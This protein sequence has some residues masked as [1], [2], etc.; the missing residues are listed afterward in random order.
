MDNPE[1]LEFLERLENSI[2]KSTQHLSEILELIGWEKDELME[3]PDLLQCQIDG[4]HFVPE[5]IKSRHNKYCELRRQNLTREE[6]KEM[7]ERKIYNQMAAGRL[8]FGADDITQFLPKR[9]PT[10]TAGPQPPDLHL[11]PP[12]VRLAVYDQV[13]AKSRER[14]Q[15]ESTVDDELF[16]LDRKGWEKKKE[17][18]DNKNKS[19]VEQLAEKRDQRRR[20]QTYRAKNVHIT[21]KSHTEIIREVINNQMEVLERIIQDEV[22]EPTASAPAAGGSR[23]GGSHEGSQRDERSSREGEE[24]SNRRDDGEGSHHKKHKRKRSRSRSLDREP[25]SYKESHHK[26]HKKH[27]HKKD[28]EKERDNPADA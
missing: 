16:F 19:F 2:E 20:R 5:S 26:R 1:K 14:E 22:G 23:E 3:A 10:S 11:H 6:A 15:V 8:V 4:N 17:E 21:S 7:L 25:S 13:V 24:R 18:S 9:H 27:K 12:D 28:K